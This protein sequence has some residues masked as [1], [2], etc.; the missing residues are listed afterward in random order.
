[1]PNC[2]SLTSK[3]TGQVVALRQID[4]E[5]C[6]YFGVVQ[7]KDGYYYH[8]VDTIGF[9]LATGQLFPD[10]IQECHANMAKQPDSAAYYETKLK[11]AG[12][13]SANFVSDAWAVK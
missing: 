10:I 11:I 7:D 6:E 5:M 3:S 9:E 12:Y 13:L 2:F 4:K 8:W 1:M